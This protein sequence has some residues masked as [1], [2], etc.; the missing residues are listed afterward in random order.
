MN[1][2]LIS[3]ASKSGKKFNKFNNKSYY[4]IINDKNIDSVYIST[5]N[6][7]HIE[8][9]DKLCDGNKN[10]L[11]EK[12]ASISLDKLKKVE[13]KIKNKNINFFEAVA[14][15]SH[16][17]TLEILNLINNEIGEIRELESNF[18]LKQDLSQ[19][20]DYLIKI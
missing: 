5:L 9:I 18:G 1:S 19:D 8:L 13:K 17:Q 10:I 14:Y 6:D 2:N 12:P 4:E 7:T 3:I 15:Y 16:P 20:R 11:C